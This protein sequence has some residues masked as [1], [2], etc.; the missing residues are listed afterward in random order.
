MALLRRLLRRRFGV[1]EVQMD[2]QIGRL[3]VAQ[4]A[5]LA[6]ALLDFSGVADLAAWL[7]ESQG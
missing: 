1:L 4:L 3:S 2:E 7:E 5:D 6:E